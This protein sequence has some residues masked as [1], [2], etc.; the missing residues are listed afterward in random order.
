MHRAHCTCNVVQHVKHVLSLPC[1]RYFDHLKA[2]GR[3]RSGLDD[4]RLSKHVEFCEATIQSVRPL[5]VGPNCLC[6]LLVIAQLNKLQVGVPVSAICLLLVCGCLVQTRQPHTLGY[7]SRSVF[8]AV[9]CLCVSQ[10]WAHAVRVPQASQQLQ[11]AQ[12]EH[13]ALELQRYELVS[14]WH[15]DTSNP[16]DKLTMH[17][18]TMYTVGGRYPCQGLQKHILTMISKLNS[19]APDDPSRCL[20]EA[21]SAPTQSAVFCL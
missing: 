14:G 20:H 9:F 15:H 8:G 13:N 4:L 7:E 21:Q 18:T 17:G 10:G 16:K 19:H 12:N 5:H 2:L 11:A 6:S 3:E 1:R